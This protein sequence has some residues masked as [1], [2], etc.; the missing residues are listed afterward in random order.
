MLIAT[1]RWQNFAVGVA[2]VFGVLGLGV[3]SLGALN[4]CGDVGSVSG[5]RGQADVLSVLLQSKGKNYQK[6]KT[7]ERRL[8]KLSSRILT[9]GACF[10]AVKGR[11]PS[12]IHTRT[13]DVYVRMM[14]SRPSKSRSSG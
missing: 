6:S 7:D 8:T 12:S 2:N 3:L 9:A 14:T 4:F 13:T 10:S 5:E 11:S 1:L